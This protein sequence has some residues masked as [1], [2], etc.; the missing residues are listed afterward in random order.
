MFSGP[1]SMLLVVLFMSPLLFGSVYLWSSTLL[2][3][4]V[5]TAFLLQVWSSRQPSPPA[6]EPGWQHRF[7]PLAIF[8]LLAFLQML[9]LPAEPFTA[10]FSQR[11]EFWR[12]PFLL[13][14]RPPE[15]PFFISFFPWGTL[16]E[17]TKFLAYAL[18]AYLTAR[19]IRADISQG[20]PLRT[21]RAL[22]WV[23]TLTGFTASLVAI[24]Q[25]GMGAKAIYGFWT[26]LHSVTFMGPYVN[27]NHLAGLLEMCLPMG[28]ALLTMQFII[29]GEKADAARRALIQRRMVTIVCL[30]LVFLVSLC[31]LLLTLSRG[32]ILAGVFA[33][34]LESMLITLLVRRQRSP[35]TALLLILAGFAA[36]LGA[37]LLVDFSA[38]TKRFQTLA[39]MDLERDLRWDLAKD[40]WDLFWAYPWLGAGLGSFPM[41]LPMF[42]T[43]TTQAIIEHAH[44]DY[45]EMLAE[46]GWLGS[47]AFFAFFIQALLRSLTQVWQ[48]QRAARGVSMDTL[49]QAVLTLGGA[50]G[51]LA[52]LLHG[53][54]EFNLRIPAN[55]L[56]CFVITGML[57]GLPETGRDT[58]INRP[59]PS[60]GIQ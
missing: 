60:S 39:I 8:L 18:A 6:G 29:P 30:G 58:Q 59:R 48:T 23:M 37:S 5:F 32:G 36:L 24:V 15:G 12:Q 27:K 16:V 26:P 55:A 1:R 22:A 44:Q 20:T 56:Y 35:G 14:Q 19:L 49:Q 43:T 45:L 13:T 34:L 3:F 10:L 41:V 33:L 21:V 4:G 7:L 54:V 51:L 47:L 46:M 11:A 25:V 28:L 42:K 9:P 17:F 40:S 57:L 31:G 53:V 50:A 38:L 2:A 52:L